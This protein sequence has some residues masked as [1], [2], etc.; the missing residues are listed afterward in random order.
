M[1]LGSNLGGGGFNFHAFQTGTEAHPATSAKDTGPVSRTFVRFGPDHPTTPI[2]EFQNGCCYNSTSPL[3]LQC[4]FGWPS[5]LLMSLSDCRLLLLFLAITID[6]YRL[7]SNSV[8]LSHL[9][10]PIIFTSFCI[11]SLILILPTW[12]IWWAP[13]NANKWQMRFNSAF[14]GLMVRSF[15]LRAVAALP[16]GCA[17][18]Y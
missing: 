3:F 2:V 16:Y 15:C 14:K 13:N 12:R 8:W 11:T 4:M 7:L 1:V 18:F 17:I 9:L 6:F 10:T 5:P